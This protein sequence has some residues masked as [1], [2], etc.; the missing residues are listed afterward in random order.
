[1]DTAD[2]L[3]LLGGAARYEIPDQQQTAWAR[4]AKP[5]TRRG[6]ALSG[7][8]CVG[9]AAEGRSG[10]LLRVLQSSR[11]EHDCAYCPLRRS[12]DPRRASFAPE[13]L[14]GAFADLH[15][16][17]RVDGLLLSSATDGSADASMTRMLDT[18]RILRT[19][20]AYE[21]YVHLKVLP[22]AER[23]ALEEAAQLAD[24][25][26]LNVEVPDARYLSGLETGK[27]WQE[28]I[29][30]R[31]SWLRYLD[32][33]GE[34][35]AGISS[36]LL[37]GVAAPDAQAAPDRAL[38]ESSRALRRQFGLRRVH[39]GDFAPAP[40][41]PLEGAPS[42]DPRRRARLYQLDWLS[43]QYDFADTEIDAAF[44]PEGQLPLDLDPKL[45]VSLVRPRERP[46]EI[47][48]ASYEDLLRV[49]GIGPISAGRILEYRTQGVLRDLADLRVLGVV[50]AR[51]APF[52]LVNGRA[53]AE[54]PAALQRLRRRLRN[55]AP[56]PVQLRLW[57]DDG[58][59]P[60]L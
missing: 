54:A 33:A 36:Q 5:R 25:L 26:S 9:E 23:A 3:A 15:R 56:R 30:Q 28:D 14:A 38:S 21:G 58:A 51:A 32:Q 16:R 59:L 11:C 19:R 1:M 46:V 57:P 17:G 41:T 29:V 8:L 7:A 31:L 24:R 50:T 37:I 53:P 34:I 13:E 42:P 12:N 2:K 45:A 44:D 35:R 47:T 52:V 49:P 40:G 43:T 55:N 18:L 20:H 39:F 22:G 60:A 27:R 6:G 4:A 10:T 48:T